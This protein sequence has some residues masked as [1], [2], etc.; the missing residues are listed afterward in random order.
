MRLRDIIVDLYIKTATSLPKDI[1][2]GLYNALKKEKGVSKKAIKVILENINI[3]KIKQ[4]PICQ[5]TGVPIF[6][7]KKP[8]FMKQSFI[9]GEIISGTKIATKLIP[10]RPNAVDVIT[11]KNSGD[12]TGRGFPIL[13]FDERDDNKLIIS[14]MLK[15]AGS[16]NISQFYK[17]P[18]EELKAERDFNG[19]KRCVIDAIYKAQG[20]GCPPYFIGVGIGATKD[21]VARLSKEQLMRKIDDVNKNSFLKSIE[22]DILHEVNKLGIGPIG[23]GGR[24]TA[25]SVKIGINHRHPATYFVDVSINCWANRRAKVVC[26]YVKENELE[27]FIDYKITD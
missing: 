19:V 18:N 26:E 1:K 23:F 24:T 2:K 5:D 13:Y 9:K 12:N 8:I 15:G 4:R 14:L 21:Q 6:F 17:L 10:L 16:E 7:I 11:N 25:L 22:D 3:S 27:E 20:M